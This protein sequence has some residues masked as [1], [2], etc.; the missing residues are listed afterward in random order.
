MEKR[1]E[2]TREEKREGCDL[3]NGQAPRRSRVALFHEIITGMSEPEAIA[4]FKE[5][6]QQDKMA[7]CSHLTMCCL[8]VCCRQIEGIVTRHAV[9]HSFA[10]VGGEFQ[11]HAVEMSLNEHCAH[12]VI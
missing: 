6:K 1:E 12:C 7:D 2:K 8:C 4:F 9:P 5:L 3:K 10:V 11:L